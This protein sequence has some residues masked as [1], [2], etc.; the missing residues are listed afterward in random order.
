MFDKWFKGKSEDKKSG[1]DKAPASLLPETIGYEEARDLAK[2]EDVNVRLALAQRSDLKAE[3]L[4]FLAEDTAPE[5]RRA[6]AG[7]A[8]APMHADLLLARDHDESVRGD[9]AAKIAKL[10]SIAMCSPNPH[11][12]NS[13]IFLRVKR[14]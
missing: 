12:S 9:L 10:A 2:H 6:I 14:V 13:P 3:I 8:T 1:H 4:Y 11:T 5:V 7:N